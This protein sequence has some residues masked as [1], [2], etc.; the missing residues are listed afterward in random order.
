MLD[1]NAGT[2]TDWADVND[3][4]GAGRWNVDPAARPRRL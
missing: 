3:G 4:G 1:C 2:A